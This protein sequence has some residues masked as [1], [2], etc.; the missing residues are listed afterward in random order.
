[1]EVFKWRELSRRAQFE[2]SFVR[3]YET[4]CTQGQLEPWHNWSAS[5][6]RDANAGSSPARLLFAW[7]SSLALTY[8]FLAI[9]SQ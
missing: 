1:M 6:I 5:S 8:V 2:L 7:M 9:K 4:P 3:G